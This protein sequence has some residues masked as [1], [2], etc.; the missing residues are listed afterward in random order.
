MVELCL[1]PPASHT[2]SFL[3]SLVVA[4]VTYCTNQPLPTRN[5]EFN[6][7]VRKPELIT[8]QGGNVMSPFDFSGKLLK[9]MIRT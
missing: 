4:G 8:H 3:P 2:N 5:N 6:N 1:I 7:A 9:L